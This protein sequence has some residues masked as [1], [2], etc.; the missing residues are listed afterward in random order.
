[1]DSDITAR[2]QRLETSHRRWRAVALFGLV[3]ALFGLVVPVLREPFRGAVAV[4]GSQRTVATPSFEQLTVGTLKVKRL[5]VLDEKGNTVVSMH[6]GA[7][8]GILS[9]DSATP[10]DHN[11]MIMA[12]PHGA[13]VQVAS[14]KEPRQFGVLKIMDRK[15]YLQ[16]YEEGDGSARNFYQAPVFR[17]DGTFGDSA[18]Q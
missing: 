6:E 11:V 2:I 1:M 5:H 16:M 14:Q 7:G 10:K 17:E 9:V 4:P 3:I 18:A 12:S 15:P 8:G 13:T